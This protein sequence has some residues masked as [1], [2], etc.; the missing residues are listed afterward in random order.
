M[1]RRP[2]VG[3][4]HGGSGRL[5]G[6]WGALLG[7]GGAAEVNPDLATNEEFGFDTNQPFLPSGRNLL[8]QS[9][10]LAGGL[11]NQITSS[12]LLGKGDLAR[13]MQ[14]ETVRSGNQLS[15][16]KAMVDYNR[17]SDLSQQAGLA[18]QQETQRM[19]L[20]QKMLE[21]AA[22][23]FSQRYPQQ[24][25]IGKTLD[26]TDP[27]YMRLAR[28]NGLGPTIEGNTATTAENINRTVSAEAQRPFIPSVTSAA[29]V[30]PLQEAEARLRNP[31]IT[32][33]ELT[34]PLDTAD[35]HRMMY[36][37]EANKV[38]PLPPVGREPSTGNIITTI[39]PSKGGYD[40]DTLKPTPPTPGGAFIG[41]KQT[42]RVLSKDQ[43]PQDDSELPH[44]T[45][46]P[47][48]SARPGVGE[49]TGPNP[50][51]FRGRVPVV[52][53]T[54]KPTISE[55]RPTIGKRVQSLLSGSTDAIGDVGGHLLN[56][57]NPKTG[58]EQL[59]MQKKEQ[60]LEKRKAQK[61]SGGRD[62]KVK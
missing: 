20:Q 44:H 31:I 3:G 52:E 27:A 35:T 23:Y 46:S 22:Y 32:G 37:Q 48:V 15:N 47:G 43:I 55:S 49:R 29:T 10:A 24:S 16:Q 28:L 21:D 58:D 1:P 14:L 38:Q 26:T 41:N 53:P 11:N 9:D 61:K 57:L 6:L 39:P 30:R 25:I 34:S 54:G 45:P 33:R 2:A 60:E 59:E 18:S 42:F 12:N 17:T 51:T 56:Y 40:P 19:A 4:G 50:E 7:G 8:G 5:Q 36:R 62:V 13:Q